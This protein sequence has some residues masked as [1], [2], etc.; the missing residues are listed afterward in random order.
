VIPRDCTNTRLPKR[1][2]RDDSPRVSDKHKVIYNLAFALCHN[3]LVLSKLLRDLILFLRLTI[4]SNIVYRKYSIA[5]LRHDEL[6]R[7]PALEAFQTSKILDRIV[8]LILIPTSP[9]PEKGI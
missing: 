8:T 7:L 2:N 6:G 5:A 9:R 3:F 1:E 4:H